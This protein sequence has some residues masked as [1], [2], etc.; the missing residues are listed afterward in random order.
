[1][2]ASA[3]LLCLLPS[4]NDLWFLSLPVLFCLAE[5]RLVGSRTLVLHWDFIAFIIEATRFVHWIQMPLIKVNEEDNVMRKH[6]NRC[7]V[8]ILI[9]R[10]NRSSMKVHRA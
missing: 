1:M 8:G 5:L 9:I 2:W 3:F 4:F 6:D 10:A 7:I